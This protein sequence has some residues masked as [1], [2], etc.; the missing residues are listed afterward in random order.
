MPHNL[1]EVLGWNRRVDA[2]DRFE[3]HRAVCRNASR[4]ASAAADLKAASHESA[5]WYEPSSNCARTSVMGC[6]APGARLRASDC[7]PELP[8]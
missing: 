5:S 8:A 4:V 2:H 7:R 3:Q 1:G 6:P